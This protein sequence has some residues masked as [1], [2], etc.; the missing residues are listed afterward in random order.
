MTYR[1]SDW[2]RPRWYIATTALIALTA[3]SAT[4]HGYEQQW[5]L[6]PD[7]G[8]CTLSLPEANVDGF[9]AGVHATYGINDTFNLRAQADLASFALPAP[10]TSALIYGGLLG[11]EYVVDILDWIPYAGVVLGPSV[12]A[13]RHDKTVTQLAAEIPFGMGYQ[14]GRNWAVAV[15]GRYR[16]L[17]GGVA[18]SPGSMFTLFARVEYVMGKTDR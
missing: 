18:E 9:A 14:L 7:F 2:M 15:E 12:M 13:I 8:F 16:M 11:A 17:F 3:S 5:R 4:S 10:S 6:G 1:H